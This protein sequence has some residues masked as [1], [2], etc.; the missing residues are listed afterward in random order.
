MIMNRRTAMTMLGLAAACPWAFA[1]NANAANALRFIIGMD[2]GGGTDLNARL[3]VQHLS[4]HFG[5]EISVE[6]D[7]R[8]GGVTALQSALGETSLAVSTL[9]TTNIFDAAIDDQYPLDIKKVALLDNFVVATRV[10]AIRSDLGIKSIADWQA[11]GKKLRF[12]TRTPNYFK[13]VE[14]NLLSKIWGVDVVIVPGFSTNEARAAFAAG[15]LDLI[16]GSYTS[17]KKSTKDGS[18][19]LLVRTSDPAGEDEE[20]TNLPAASDFVKNETYAPLLPVMNSMNKLQLALATSVTAAPEAGDLNAALSATKLDPAFQADAAKAGL[21]IDMRTGDEIR[22]E[23]SKLI[24]DFDN[25][26]AQFRKLL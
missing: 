21:A 24:A 10:V 20:S 1:N 8:A 3:L 4:R 19:L 11:S 6:N 17:T 12:G 23:F 5:G 14:M 7:G 25:I 15:E 16:A 13:G 2:A 22:D 18:G 26:R 9:E